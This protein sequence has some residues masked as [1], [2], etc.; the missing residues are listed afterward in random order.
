MSLIDLL[1]LFKLFNSIYISLPFK[2]QN[3]NY[4]KETSL[5]KN[6]IYKDIQTTFLVGTPAQKITISAC[7]GE[8][9]TFILSHDAKGFNGSIY[10]KEISK[11]FTSYTEKPEFYFFQIFNKGIDSLDNFYIEK[12]KTKINNLEFM[13][14][15]EVGVNNCHI[16][17]CE[18]LTQPGILGFL[19]KEKYDSLNI[20]KLNFINQLKQKNLISDYY[21]NFHFDTEDSGNIVIGEKPHEYDNLHYNENNY[22]LTQTVILQKDID[23]RMSFDKIYYGE[24]EM[25]NQKSVILRIEYGLIMGDFPWQKYLESN[26]FNKYINETKC[27]KNKTTDTENYFT[28]Y[29]CNK[30]IDLSEFKP[31]SF[32]INYFN[33]NF[34]LTKDDLFIQDDNKYIFLMVF[35]KY[36]LI[37]G[38]P[39]LK[40]Y[41]LIFNQ[42]SKTI[43]FYNETKNSESPNNSF[44][45]YYIAI[46]ILSIIL[47]F[48][49][50]I[51]I[52]LYILRNKNKKKNAEELTNEENEIITDIKNTNLINENN[53]IN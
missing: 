45:I 38:Y 23:W 14:A 42:N 33:Y 44:N 50:G 34:T 32:Y 24:N 30:N 27:F 18:V 51:T 36:D 4:E 10:N 12:S 39:F 7:L 26:F 43:G 8:Y 13:L 40:K 41:Q 22:L 52:Y 20:T 48:L 37:F 19:I 1:L 53:G 47:I 6:Y 5:I 15:T 16:N 3:F 2:I 31:F 21:F 9:T 25:E 17:Y 49:I 11:S 29:Y 35:G 28:F 46:I